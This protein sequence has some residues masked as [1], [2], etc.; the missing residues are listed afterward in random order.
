MK[1]KRL[2]IK[3]RLFPYK[4]LTFLL[5]AEPVNTFEETNDKQWF[6]I[7]EDQTI[8]LDTGEAYRA[9]AVKSDKLWEALYWLN[10]NGLLTVSKTRR[11]GEAKITLKYP[12]N[13]KP[14]P[15]AATLEYLE[16]VSPLNE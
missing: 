9:L 13:I 14:T 11:R 4:L 15:T 12:S 16:S 6:I 7:D 8:L 2:P 5:Y 3:D 10:D 1:L